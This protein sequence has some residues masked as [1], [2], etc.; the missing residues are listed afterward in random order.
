MLPTKQLEMAWQEPDV[1]YHSN[2]SDNIEYSC[3]FSKWSLVASKITINRPVSNGIWIPQNAKLKAICLIFFGTKCSPAPL[4]LLRCRD[5]R[6][7]ERQTVLCE[8]YLLFCFCSFFSNT[9]NNI[10]RSFLYK[11][12]RETNHNHTYKS[13]KTYGRVG[14]QKF[15]TSYIMT[16]GI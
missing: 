9:T 4:I 11:L 6:S 14:T 2:S 3:I 16:F 1:N 7:E 8:V 5:W 10:L 12:Q 15:H 13:H